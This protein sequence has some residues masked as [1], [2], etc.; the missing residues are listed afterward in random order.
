MTI[1]RFLLALLLSIVITLALAAGYVFYPIIAMLLSQA[2]RGPETSGVAAV[3]GGGGI[4][5]STLLITEVVVF[6]ILFA[7]LYRRRTNE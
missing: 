1:Q 2:A 6:A 4:R 3:G 5:S 7:V